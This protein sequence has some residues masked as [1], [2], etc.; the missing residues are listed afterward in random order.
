MGCFLWSKAPKSQPFH[1]IHINT[2]TANL[3]LKNM[4]DAIFAALAS[5]I[6]DQK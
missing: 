5:N 4:D 1:A 3:A 2:V 6:K